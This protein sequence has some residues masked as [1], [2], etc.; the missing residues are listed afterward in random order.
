MAPHPSKE[1]CS[2]HPISEWEKHSEDTEFEDTGI[3][4]SSP[5]VILEKGGV[6]GRV[7]PHA[8]YRLFSKDGAGFQPLAALST[9]SKTGR[10]RSITSGVT[11]KEMRKYPARP[12]PLPGTMSSRSACAAFTNATSSAMGERGNR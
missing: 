3:E 4:L 7:P 1:Q 11:Q 6:G 8:V 9:F 10:A 5:G 12:N 2:P